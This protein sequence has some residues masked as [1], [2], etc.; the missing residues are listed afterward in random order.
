VR[1]KTRTEHDTFSIGG[2]IGQ[3]LSGNH[4]KEVSKQRK[5]RK[6]SIH[7]L[8]CSNRLTRLCHLKISGLFIKRRVDRGTQPNP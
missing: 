4:R 2:R 8:Y 3:E 5:K 7:I 1:K 6:N